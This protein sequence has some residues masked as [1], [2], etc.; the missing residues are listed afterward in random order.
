MAKYLILWEEDMSKMPVDPNEQAALTQ[1]HM[2]LTKQALDAGQ[3]TDWGIFAGGGAGYAIGEGD[4]A[5]MFRGAMQFTPHVKF[6]AITVLS[7]SEVTEVMKSMM[8]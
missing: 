6:K 8:G 2:E 4:A 5:D 1:K 3:I 7:I